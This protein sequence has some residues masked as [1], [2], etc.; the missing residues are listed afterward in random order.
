MK[1]SKW[2]YVP[3]QTRLEAFLGFLFKTKIKTYTKLTVVMCCQMVATKPVTPSGILKKKSFNKIIITPLPR[4]LPDLH[5]CV[6]SMNFQGLLF[7]L[8]CW[9]GWGVPN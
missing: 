3:V 8:F 1:L 7:V 9:L 6:T 5:E 2:D 4:P